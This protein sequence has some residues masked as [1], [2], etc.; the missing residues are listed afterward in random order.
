MID[1]QD[2][3]AG[4]TSRAST[5]AGLGLNLV[6]GLAVQLGATLLLDPPRAHVHLTL[7]ISVPAPV[8]L[9]A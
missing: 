8:S 1:Y 9:A 2:D 7:P 5:S 4:W 6:R 3:G